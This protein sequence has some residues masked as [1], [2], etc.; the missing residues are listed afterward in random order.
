M[1]DVKLKLAY[2][3]GIIDGEGSIGICR[4]SHK[5]FME[6]YKRKY[7]YYYPF[8]RCGMIDHEPIKM[9]KEVTKLGRLEKEI[10]YQE[11]R[12]MYRWRI[13]KQKECIEFI[14]LL[15]PYLIVKK[16]QAILMLDFIKNFKRC[17]R[18]TRITPEIEAE[19]ASYWIKM[20]TLNGIASPATTE[21]VGKVGRS[22]SVRPGNDSLTSHE[23]V[24]G[25]SEAV[26]PPSLDG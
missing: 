1:E 22:R 24:R 23:S 19:R 7:P 20:R 16:P 6:Q 9:I 2:I 15:F 5:S 10:S 18:Y 4:A 21:R 26:Y 25:E 8:I 17:H 11:K 13:F 3:A 12:P 14:N